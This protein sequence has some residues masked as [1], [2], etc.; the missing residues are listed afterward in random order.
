MRILFLSI[1]IILISAL[2]IFLMR[3]NGNETLVTDTQLSGSGTIDTNIIDKINVFVSTKNGLQLPV[4]NFISDADVYTW[5]DDST[6]LIGQNN[7]LKGNLYQIF[8]YAK[9]GS[10]VISLQSEPLAL[11]RVIAE[12][13]LIS[14]LGVTE[15]ELCS[16][17]IRVST[18]ASVNEEFSGR[19][20]GLS[21]CQNNITL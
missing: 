18:P 10:I 6:Y 7:D 17:N 19:E 16:L 4:R 14:R 8:Y 12:R 15:Q 3:G 1:C 13:E 21:F 11:A 20:L 9:D 2:I 5:Y